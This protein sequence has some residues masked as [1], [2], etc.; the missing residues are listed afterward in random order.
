MKRRTILRTTGAAAVM[1]ST[2]TL[3]QAWPSRPITF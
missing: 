2:G 1:A 3:A